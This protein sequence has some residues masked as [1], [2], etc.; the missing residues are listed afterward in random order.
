MTDIEIGQRIKQN[1]K[2]NGFSNQDVADILHYSDRH[3][4]S[5]FYSGKKKFRDDQIKTLATAWSVRPE[6]LKGIDDWET[7][8]EMLSADAARKLTEYTAILDYLKTLGL[9]L[10]PTLCFA[11]NRYE[12]YQSYYFLKNSISQEGQKIISTLAHAKSRPLLLPDGDLCNY[13]WDNVHWDIVRGGD[14]SEHYESRYS[15][16]SMS[17]KKLADFCIAGDWGIDDE[18]DGEDYCEPNAKLLD[19]QLQKKS[20]RRYDESS[21]AKIYIPLKSDPRE[22]ET[23]FTDF[24]TDVPPNGAPLKDLTTMT[25]GLI[26]HYDPDLHIDLSVPFDPDNPVDTRSPYINE[27]RYGALEIRYNAEYNGKLIT[28]LAVDRVAAF[29]HQVDALAKVSIE[30]SLMQG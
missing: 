21:L 24:Y 17:L 12:F 10:S 8:D 11:G 13:E 15:E 22:P 14:C 25:K 26:P 7:A 27:L 2:R 28:T 9:Y 23:D 29:F 16:Q 18:L 30:T 1:A 19:E 4:I 5:D 6:Y 3:Q 20:E